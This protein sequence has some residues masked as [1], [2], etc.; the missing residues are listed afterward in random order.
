M[1]TR[2]NLLYSASALRRM[3]GLMYRRLHEIQVREW[4]SVVWVWVPGYRPRFMAKAEFKRHF[5]EW[6]RQ[7]ARALRV[8]P[9]SDPAT[10]RFTVHNCDKQSSYVVEVSDTAVACTC[11]DYG[12]QLSAWGKGCCKHGYAVL[13]HLG[14]SSLSEYLGLCQQRLQFLAQHQRAA[15]A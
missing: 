5:V 4:W 15:V 9:W 1:V 14:F 10:G 12:N 13:G 2:S 11:D 6:R 8:V 7:A 3:W